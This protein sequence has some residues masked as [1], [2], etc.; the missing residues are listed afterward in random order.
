[1]PSELPF[2]K[3]G[4][5]SC[6]VQLFFFSINYPITSQIIYLLQ[7]V[8]FWD[9]IFK[10]IFF[11]VCWKTLYWFHV[12]ERPLLQNFN[13]IHEVQVGIYLIFCFSQFL[14]VCNILITHRS[15]AC[16][17]SVFSC[18]PISHTHSS[19]IFQEIDLLINMQFTIVQYT[20]F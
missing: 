6:T 16:S 9:I 14:L 12:A 15:L 2:L 3:D 13:S 20:Y 7:V 8:L 19:P 4:Q 10:P 11:L 1:M 17:V 18:L 5:A